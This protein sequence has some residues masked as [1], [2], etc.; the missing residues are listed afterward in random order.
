MGGI[1]PGRGERIRRR[2]R[3][4]A[5]ERLSY[6]AVTTAARREPPAPLRIDQ[7][8]A[9]AKRGTRGNQGSPARVVVLHLALG[10]FFQGHRQ[11]VLRARL[12]ERGRVVVEGS[13]TELVVVVVDLPSA[14]R[15]D[16]HQRVAGVDTFEQLVDAW[17][18]H[19]CGMVPAASSSR[20]TIV[21]SVSTARSR[22]S[23]AIT[24]SKRSRSSH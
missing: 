13:L 22:S 10:D 8:V 11:V 20:R 6:G 21:S 9:P 19:G 24:W 5:G 1:L 14:L 17:M 23:F 3:A 16:D 2:A 7:P 12:D 4:P 18:D 15:R